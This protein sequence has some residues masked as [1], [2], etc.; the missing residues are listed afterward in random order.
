MLEEAEKVGV[1]RIL[2]TPHIRSNEESKEVAELHEA[3][4]AELQQHTN[5]PLHLSGEVRLTPDIHTLKD[6]SWLTINKASKYMLL[7]LSFQ[8]YPNY[9]QQVLFDLRLVGITPILAHPERYLA[10][11]RK[12]DLVFDIVR[13]GCHLQLTASSISGGLGESIQ[14]LSLRLLEAGL[15][16]IVASDAHNISTRPFRDWGPCLDVLK[17]IEN[18]RNSAI[19]GPD[20]VDRITRKNPESICLD[21][22]I[23]PLELTD[24]F[25]QQARR[26][27]LNGSGAEKKRKRFFFF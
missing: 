24:D 12:P 27:L 2:T 25:E 15:V 18:D 22:P 13:M 23:E 5:F 9:L 4:F 7:E 11:L 19:L 17:T 26:V 1:T 20:F 21:Q 10:I 6:V 8:E 14:S 3:R 16:S